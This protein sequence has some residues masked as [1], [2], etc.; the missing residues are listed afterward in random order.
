MEGFFEAE[1]TIAELAEQSIATQPNVVRST[2]L[3]PTL[4]NSLYIKLLIF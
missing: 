1:V 3:N 4:K 2:A